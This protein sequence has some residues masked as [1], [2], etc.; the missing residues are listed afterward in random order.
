[1][2]KLNIL[3][4]R[5]YIPIIILSIIIF[6]FSHQSETPNH[7]P[8]F[9]WSDKILHFF[10]FLIYGSTVQYSLMYKIKDKKSFYFMCLLIGVLFG[11]SDEIHQSFIPGR[12]ADIFDFIADSFGIATSLL[13][14]KYIIIIDKLI[15]K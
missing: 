9:E 6:Y 2:K 15:F 7:F 13:F 11:A 5:Y 3:K 8:D 14:R 1:M 4:Y 10:A 12:D